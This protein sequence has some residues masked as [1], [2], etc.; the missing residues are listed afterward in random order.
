MTEELIPNGISEARSVSNGVGSPTEQFTPLLPAAKDPGLRWRALPALALILLFFGAVAITLE[1]ENTEHAPQIIQSAAAAATARNSFEGVEL[2][3]ESAIV[4]DLVTGRTLYEKNPDIQLPLASLTKV[5][6]VLAVSEVLPLGSVIT[7]PYDTSPKGSVE[8]LAK[9]EEWPVKDIIDFT[10]VASSNAGAEILASVADDAIRERFSDAP[11]GF[12]ALWRMN[13]LAQELGLV[14]TYFLNASG[15]DVSATLSGAYGSA[16]DMA[17]LFSYAATAKSAVFDGTAENG[18]ILTS[19]NGGA[20]TIAFNTNEA[21]GDIP[22][23]IMGKT[24]MTHLAGG[25]LAIVFEVGPAHPIV[26]VV[27]GS[28][29][30]DRFSDMKMLISRTQQAI[31]QSAETNAI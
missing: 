2:S 3:A 18:L 17:K 10:L 12:A 21:L 7:I 15:L 9:D 14:H 16:R 6:L 31:S 30:E 25:N 29:S 28:T 22:G 4:V 26:A 8:R 19:A 5:A 11:E 13:N 24:G 20:K 1:Y 27:L 23:L